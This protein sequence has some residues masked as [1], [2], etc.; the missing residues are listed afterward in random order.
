MKFTKTLAISLLTL[1]AMQFAMAEERTISLNEQYPDAG[2]MT[3]NGFKKGDTLKLLISECVG[4]HPKYNYKADDVTYATI[5]K[6]Q[7][8]DM[9]GMK[10]KNAFLGGSKVVEFKVTFKDMPTKDP[11]IIQNEAAKYVFH[12]NKP[13][14]TL[15]LTGKTGDVTYPDIEKGENAPM[16]KVGDVIDLVFSENR[17]VSGAEKREIKALPKYLDFMGETFDA[18]STR[19]M[20]APGEHHMLFLVK[21]QPAKLLGQRLRL[22]FGD[23]ALNIKFVVEKPVIAK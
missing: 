17:T 15:N 3:L 10:N 5:E 14:R 7:P 20:G 22:M 16:L 9:V 8:E 21:E 23:K 4:C 18:P 6:T 11:I 1:G 12:F 13:T 19:M 2:D